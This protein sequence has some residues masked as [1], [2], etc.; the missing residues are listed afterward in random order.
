MPRFPIGSRVQI[1]CWWF[2]WSTFG[3]LWTLAFRWLPGQAPKTPRDGP[4]LLVANHTSAFDPV[5]I[6][7][8]LMRRSSFMASSALFRLPILGRLLPLCGCFP[9]EKFVKDRDSMKTLAE[10]YAA[11]DVIVMFPEG[12][13]TFDGRTRPVLPGIGRLVKR[14][15][16][17]VV[18]ARILNGHLF[19]PR[20]AKFPRWIPI[21]VE[22]DPPRE[23]GPD[24]TVEEINAEISRAITIDPSAAPTGWWSPGFRMAEGLPD[25][26]WAC[27]DCFQQE[28]LVAK[29]SRVACQACGSAWTVDN[30]GRMRGDTTLFV[31]EAH[32]RIAE[33]FGDHDLSGQARLVRVKGRGHEPLDEGAATLTAEG[34]QVGQTL[35]PLRELRAVSVE[36]QNRLTFRHGDELLELL[37]QGQSTLKWGH[38]LARRLKATTV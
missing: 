10:R 6:A 22:H 2:F 4:F 35:L 33:H 26:L 38:F 11:G 20:W 13:R 16:A 18:C 24:A 7:Y 28:G 23:W 17:R 30:A 25:F 21:R 34:L 3:P 15:N 14:L 9:K 19:H 27:P 32:D 5:W 29:G 37:P 1:A 8:F 31:H 36:V 12:T